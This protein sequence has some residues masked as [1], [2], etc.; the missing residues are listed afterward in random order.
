MLFSQFPD[1]FGVSYKDSDIFS[2]KEFN[3]IYELL[4]T[5]TLLGH[6]GLN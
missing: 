5:D 6:D 3:K 4:R 1:R 2:I